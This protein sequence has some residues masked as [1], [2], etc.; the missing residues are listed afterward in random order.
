MAQVAQALTADEV[1]AI[2]QW[3]AVQPVPEP[4]HPAATLPAALPISC[5][6][7]PDV[8]KAAP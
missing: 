8:T 4:A 7:V 1:G 2:A 5:G 6:G 3:L